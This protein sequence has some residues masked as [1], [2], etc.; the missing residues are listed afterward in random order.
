MLR[1]AVVFLLY[2]ASTYNQTIEFCCS[3]NV[4]VRT[5]DGTPVPRAA[6]R[7]ESGAIKYVS[8]TDENGDAVVT[9]R[10][11]GTYRAI[12]SAEGYVSETRQF[13]IERDERARVEISLVR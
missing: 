7:I 4:R 6:I 2:A 13:N 5:A 1:V 10:T 8:Q 11:P 12:A 9:L 3:V